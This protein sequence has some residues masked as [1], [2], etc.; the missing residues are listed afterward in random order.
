M[1]PL[2]SIAKPVKPPLSNKVIITVEPTVIGFPFN[3]SGFTP[4]SGKIFPIIP[5]ISLAVMV[6]SSAII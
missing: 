6:S 5:P 3:E 4:L 1:L 2:L